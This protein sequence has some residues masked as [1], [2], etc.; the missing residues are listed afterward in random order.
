MANIFVHDKLVV[1]VRTVNIR[2]EVHGEDEHL[3]VDVGLWLEPGEGGEQWDQVMADVLDMP[4]DQASEFLTQ[5]AS[6]GATK[7]QLGATY[8]LHTV[9]F[10]AG[11]KK[12]AQMPTAKINK[13]VH[14]YANE[15]HDERVLF[16]VQ[17]E[18]DGQV[19]AALSELIGRKVR[20][21][22]LGPPQAEMD[23]GED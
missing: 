15:K 11:S 5:V 1:L 17:A 19:V 10:W 14:E 20:I 4:A 3:A 12:L 23:M 2:T 18:A 22:T 21:E 13:F 6:H 7:Y 8:D 16:R 9:K